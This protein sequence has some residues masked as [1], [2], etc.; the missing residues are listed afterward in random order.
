MVFLTFESDMFRDRLWSKPRISNFGFRC[1]CLIYRHASH[2]ASPHSGASTTNRKALTES[3]WVRNKTAKDRNRTEKGQYVAKRSWGAAHYPIKLPPM[4]TQEN[5]T[6]KRIRK[7]GDSIAST[8]YKYI[9]QGSLKITV[10][11]DIALQTRKFFNQPK[12]LRNPF[13]RHA[14]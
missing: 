6:L 5:P 9:V 14:R 4:P 11:P 8:S 7:S 12:I 10:K 1:Q 2:P 3:I 13:R